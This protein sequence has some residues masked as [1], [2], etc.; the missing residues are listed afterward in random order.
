MIDF[1]LRQSGAEIQ[2]D[3]DFTESL[4]PFFSETST[5]E[6]GDIVRYQDKIYKCTSAIA[7]PEY[8]TGDL[9]WAECT[10]DEL[11]AAIPEVEVNPALAGTEPDLT[12]IK[13]GGSKYKVPQPI[14]VEANPTLAGTEA[15]L[16]G[17]KVGSTKYQVPQPTTVEANPT[18][19]GTEANL[20]GLQVGNTKYKVVTQSDVESAVN[21]AVY[22]AIDAAY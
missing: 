18:L 22:G 9:H 6:V 8:W 17:L 21:T 11:L 16:T 3:L 5:Y 4:F 14:D 10:V 15:A 13:V 12:G 2:E 1:E 7:I 20:A 19:A